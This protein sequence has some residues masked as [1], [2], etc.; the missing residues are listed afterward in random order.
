MTFG[1]LKTIFANKYDQ[2][3]APATGDEIRNRF[4]NLAVES[5]FIRR[6]WAWRLKTGSGDTDGSTVFDL[7]D[8]FSED[9][10][11][12]NTFKI[13][14]E[15]WTQI[16]EGDESYYSDDSSVFYIRGNQADGFEA[17]F[18]CATPE[19]GQAVTYRYYRRHV[20]YDD[21]DDIC[22]VPSGEAVAD[23]AVGNYLTSEG[24][25]NEALPYLESAENAINEMIKQENRGK[26]RRTMTDTRSYYG[27]DHYNPK[28]MY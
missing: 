10:I 26:A 8:D 5:I 18:P 1:N 24:E 23:L 28:Q 27:R 19:S 9:G 11:K 15:V 13:G 17:V 25:A 3:G 6:P 2:T 14:G 21:D 4:I 7:A 20:F 16:N 12:Q 22:P